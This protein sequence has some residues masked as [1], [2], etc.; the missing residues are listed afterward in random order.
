VA[1]LFCAQRPDGSFDSARPHE[2][3]KLGTPARNPP[4]EFPDV[5][6]EK[7]CA[8]AEEKERSARIAALNDAFRKEPTRIGRA[9]VTRG[10]NDLGPRRHPTYERQRSAGRYNAGQR[11]SPTT[12][13]S[14]TISGVRF[15]SS[16]A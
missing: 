14:L 13:S 12:G 1:G 16:V 8:M 7:E 11:Q 9:V 10:V 3:L 15:L 2:T 4:P 5:D 6:S